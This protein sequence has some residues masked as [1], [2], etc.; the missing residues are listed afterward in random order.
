MT[1]LRTT[2]LRLAVGVAGLALVASAAS[3]RPASADPGSQRA[4]SPPETVSNRYLVIGAGPILRVGGTV[5]VGGVSRVAA[6]TGSA[7]V[8]AASSGTAAPVKAPVAGGSV[9]AAIPDGTGGWYIGGTFTNVGGVSRP[10]LAHLSRGG[11]LDTVFSPPALG[12]VRALALDAGRL[13]VGGVEPL[14]ADPWFRPVL[15]AIDPVTGASLPVSYPP[16]AHTDQ[17]PAF[18]V[19]ALAAHDG[20][21]FAAFN[22]DNGIAAY[23]ESGG[24]ALWSRPGTPSYG[25]L[26]GPAALALAGGK[27]L[28]G[29]E[30]STPGGAVNLEELDPA[31]GAPIGQP[32]VDGPVYGIA[33]VA[34][35]AYVLAQS[36]KVYGLRVWKLG[37]S[38]GVLTRWSM[39]R[40][41]TAIVA[42][43]STLYVAGRLAVHGNAQVYALPLAQANPRLRAL[44][45]VFVGGGVHALAVHSG[46]LFVGG[47]FRGT[48]GVDRAGLAAFDARTGALLPW[49]PSVQRGHV[50][51]LASSGKKIY[52]AGSFKSVWGMGRA[53]LAA[54]S[55]LGAGQ[56]LSWHVRLSQGSFGSL[57]VSQGRVFAGGSAKRPGAKPSTPFRHLLVFSARTGRRLPF[58]SR[59]GHVNLMAVARRLVLAESNCGANGV[60]S[61][62]VTAFRVKGSGHAVWRQSI[63]GTVSALGVKAST[64]YVGGRFS[65][66]DGQPRTNL[67]AL[68]LDGSGTLLDF[69]P[70]VQ[71]PVIA[72]VPTDYGLIFAT[73][74]FGAESSP[75]FIGAQALGAAS[76]AGG[77]IPWRIDFPP[78]DIPLSTSDTAAEAGNFAIEH[79][80]AVR[81]G[82]VAS[83]DFS[84]IGPD[85]DPA[86]GSLVWFH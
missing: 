83:G 26:A 57:A 52:L 85:V 76:A 38:S 79:L 9:Q 67:A 61:A 44:S 74:A 81:G 69:A 78:N 64:L 66:V 2:L 3:T 10:G 28:V 50:S 60:T 27:L 70:Q 43:G 48:G 58:T 32:A 21:L 25:A 30:I 34:N 29:G 46:Q 23:A 71:L 42:G 7:L 80:A 33:T 15:S 24:A 77:G 37:L 16:L 45:P 36:P 49:R 51:A 47:A 73:Y 63:D 59:I 4:E 5:Y 6:P 65:S 53:G 68:A 14:G 72:V 20:S 19:I 56:L 8:V 11:T 31:T 40:G 84:W 13:Y 12:Q 18:G 75:S 55:A 39:V 41:A 54:V 1:K 82:L 62:C 22:G 86:A 35:A 17:S